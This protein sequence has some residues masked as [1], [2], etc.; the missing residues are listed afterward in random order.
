MCFYGI[1]LISL[2]PAWNGSFKLAAW[3]T[4]W[5]SANW[6]FPVLGCITQRISSWC[7]KFVSWAAANN[8]AFCWN[9]SWNSQ[10]VL[11]FF[12]LY[13]K[14]LEFFTTKHMCQNLC[15]S[16]FYLKN[17]HIVWAL[18]STSLTWLTA[19]YSHWGERL[20]NHP[21]WKHMSKCAESH[22]CEANI[23][24]TFACNFSTFFKGSQKGFILENC[25][26]NLNGV[27]DFRQKNFLK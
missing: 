24:G 7:P 17:L 23:L 22:R 1:N 26:Q 20:F 5:N 27:T 10:T 14:K 19:S 6:W 3:G 15:S 13:I 25:L 18:S 11:V 12:D 2:K 4:W 16:I 8:C 21:K 9:W